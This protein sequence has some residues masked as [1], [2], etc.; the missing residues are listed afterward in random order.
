MFCPECKAEYRQGFTHC[1]DCDVD[2]V[3]ELPQDPQHAS[4]VS[5]VAEFD[6]PE[7][8]LQLIW[9]GYSE[10]ECVNVCLD[11]RKS[12]I[13]YRVAQIPE[14][15]D[16]KTAATRRY[17]ISVP[18]SDYVRAKNLLGIEGEFFD[19][20][21][22]GDADEGAI[23]DEAE[24][25]PPDDSSPEE[26]VRNASYLQPWYPE[27]AIVEV[28]S[29]DGDDISGAI[30]MALKENLIHCRLDRQDVGGRVFVLPEDESRAR[31]I[32]R[33]ITEG[34]LPPE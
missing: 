9:K 32:I 34:G 7:L 21:Q 25:I 22:T 3:Y 17:E 11:L 6:D 13:A 27:D 31:Q 14:P 16:L 30:E 29:Q 5:G 8:E 1:V 4:R 12:D 2:L 26:P 24:T 20:C 10:A 28:W 33:E 18:K 23:A 15:P 19:G